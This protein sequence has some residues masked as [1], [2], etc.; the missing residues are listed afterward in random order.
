MYS[1]T[2][3]SRLVRDQEDQKFNISYCT[4]VMGSKVDK[5]SEILIKTLN[6]A[7]NIKSDIQNTKPPRI[8]DPII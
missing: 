3:R 7:E 4:Y 1:M 2:L 5:L 8:V 6:A